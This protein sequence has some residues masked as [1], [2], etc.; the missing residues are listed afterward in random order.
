ME[1]D[2]SDAATGLKDLH[3]CIE[4]VFD[5]RKLVVDGDAECLEDAL[6]GMPRAELRGCRNRV[7]NRIDE[8][9]AA[10]I[11]LRH[12]A[13][14]DS[15]GDLARIALFAVAREH[16]AELALGEVGEQVGGGVAPTRIHA[17]VERSIDGVGEATLGL[18]DLHRGDAKVEQDRVGFDVLDGE[19]TEAL[20][21]IA[22]EEPHGHVGMRGT[23]R[24][25]TVL[26][27][28]VAI[29]C[30]VGP[31]P[32]HQLGQHRGVSTSAKGAVDDGHTR[33]HVEQGHDFVR[34]HGIMDCG[35]SGHH[36]PGVLRH[37]R[38]YL[39]SRRGHVPRPRDPKFR[40][41]HEHQRRRS[42]VGV[43]R[44]A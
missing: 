22:L 24:A 2:D 3:G 15:A 19:R 18:V 11:G 7:P 44:A 1:R 37:F 23:K 12:A 34:E 25:G 21:E 5:H 39:P 33:L 4:A 9:S 29:D 30:D 16:V 26:D 40:V 14:A 8:V 35:V 42:R 31:T 36:G 6:S 28:G 41:D 43:R 13:T 10:L 32:L 17:H 27:R 20:D 38:H